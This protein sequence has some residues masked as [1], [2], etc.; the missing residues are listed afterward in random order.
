MTFVVIM[1]IGLI[2]LVLAIDPI[3]RIFNPHKQ[4]DQYDSKGKYVEY[5]LDESIKEKQTSLFD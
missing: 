1:A 2:L 3:D 5:W 4:A